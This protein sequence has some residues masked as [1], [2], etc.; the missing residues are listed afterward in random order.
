MKFSQ[1]YAPTLKEAPA[2]A[3]VISH[4][5][6]YRAGFIRKIAAGVYSYL[7]LAKRTLSKIE[8]IVRKEMNE[9]GAQEVSMPVI[10]PAE[11][12]KTTGRWDDYGPEMMKL[13]DR[14]ERDFTLGP[15]HEEVFTHMVKD[16]LRSY[17]QLP[18]FLYQIGPKYRD[19]IR[20][21]FGL[22]RAR[23]FIMK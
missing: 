10:Q 1:L 9:I 12:W 7:P 15:T 22:L 18:L 23:E 17:K 5:L 2:D 4:A 6:L 16:E 3:E 13:K 19:E 20:P 8:A 21:R 14:H 11:L